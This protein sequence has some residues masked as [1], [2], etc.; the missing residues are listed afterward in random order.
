MFGVLIGYRLLEPFG[1]ELAAIPLDS[2]YSLCKYALSTN[3][4][5]TA[6]NKGGNH[7]KTNIPAYPVGKVGLSGNVRRIWCMGVPH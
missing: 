4:S 5:I 3:G 1:N 2:R 6:Q 7:D